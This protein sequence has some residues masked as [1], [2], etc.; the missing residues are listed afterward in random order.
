MARKI[1]IFRRSEM[2]VSGVERSSWRSCRS[3]PRVA[4]CG[5]HAGEGETVLA[6]DNGSHCRQRNTKQEPMNGAG[7]G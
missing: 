5:R 7:E 4:E 1:V 6:V 3:T 2:S